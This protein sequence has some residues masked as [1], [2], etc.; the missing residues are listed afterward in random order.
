MFS[1]MQLAPSTS[2][3]RLESHDVATLEWGPRDGRLMIALHGFPDTAW[4]WRAVAPIFVEAGF[5]VVAPFMR[6]YAPSGIPTGGDYSVSALARDAVALAERLGGD[7]VLLGHD[8][9]AIATDALAG[10]ADSPFLKHVALAVPPL[11]WINPTRPT[12]RPWLGAVARQP[13]HSWYMAYNQIPG[14]A[15]R[16]FDR[17]SAKLWR[18]W[19]PGYD[20]TDDLAYLQEATPSLAHRRAVVSYYRALLSKGSRAAFAEP[21]HPLLALQGDQDGALDPR[22]FAAV[23]ANA[24]EGSRAEL[25]ADAGH[26]LQ[27]E[28][29]EVVAEHILEFLES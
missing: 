21:I 10:R 16:T 11:P 25:I 9:G 15:E 13:L 3:Y 4:T 5:R 17:L 27:L 6:G 7:A 12:L 26:F 28:Q 19:S 14:A 18:D 23:A 29:P 1:I 20:A 8:W 2:I 24:P 22:F